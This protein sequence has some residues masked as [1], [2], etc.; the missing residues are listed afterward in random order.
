VIV[1]VFR[2]RLKEGKSF[3]DFVEAWEADRGFDVPTRVFTA[4]NLEDPREVLTIGFVAVETEG[5]AD[6]LAATARS[7]QVRHARVDEVIESTEL[8]AM[9][10]LRAEHDFTSEPLEIEVGSFGSLLRLLV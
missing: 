10:E 9:Y 7:E 1:S 6:G 5:L 4:V 3:D 2:R 8:K